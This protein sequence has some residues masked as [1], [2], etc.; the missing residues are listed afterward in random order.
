MSEPFS[1]STNEHSG[2][3]TIDL[4]RHGEC[5]DGQI[6]RGRT[7]SA[8]TDTG[9]QQMQ[10]AVDDL[11]EETTKT[12]WQTIISSPLQRCALFSEQLASKHQLPLTID[13][14]LQEMDFGDW[15][16][17]LI[18]RVFEHNK[19]QIERFWQD[20]ESYTPPNGEPLTE[21]KQRLQNTWVRLLEQHCGQ[22]L[23]L[24][25]HGG[26]IRTLIGEL[27]HMPSH[28]LPKLSVAYGG[29]TRIQIHHHEGRPDWP[30]L[31]FHRS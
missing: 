4:L 13:S 12:P 1:V 23:L 11:I 31:V 9:W 28:A 16:G 19:D 7:D 10:Q 20:P 2:V 5:E 21:F 27:L 17:Q 25:C 14:N 8:L 29:V 6:F 26:V 24:V 3:T 15:D 18:D 22:H 30:L